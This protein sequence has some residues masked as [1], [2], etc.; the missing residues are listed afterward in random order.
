MTLTQ[1]AIF[2]AIQ[3]MDNTNHN[4]PY[5]KQLITEIVPQIVSV[6]NDLAEIETLIKIA[7]WESGGFNKDVINCKIKGDHGQAHGLFQI[8]P[9][10]M[11]EA[12]D[13]CSKD[14]AV[15]AKI[16]LDRVHL[17]IDMCKRAG[18]KGSDL[19]NGYTIGHCITNGVEAARRW[20]T[21]K[22]IVKLLE[23]DE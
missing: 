6:T 19:L 18:K 21:G 8:H 13:C 16:A 5:D 9:W 1:A 10:S 7:R 3:L 12:K 23:I 17:S 14:F 4:L 15:Q 11:Q 2:F 20:G 22:I